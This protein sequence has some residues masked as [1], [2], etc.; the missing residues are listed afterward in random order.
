LSGVSSH[1]LSS[2]RSVAEV[3]VC[4]FV[5]IASLEEKSARK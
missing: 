1:I 2:D 4:E 5:I 3:V